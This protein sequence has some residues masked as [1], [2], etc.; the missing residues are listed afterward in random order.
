MAESDPTGELESAI[1]KL[2]EQRRAHEEAIEE[3]DETFARYG[4]RPE[5]VEQP[6]RGKKKAA[7]KKAGARGKKKKKTRA[8]GKKKAATRKK[9]T[10]GKKRSSRRY[11][12]GQSSTDF[13]LSV[14][15]ERGPMT[16][17]ELSAAWKEAGR[18]GEVHQHL[19]RLLRAGRIERNKI[20]GGRTSQYSA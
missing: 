6:R 18:P 9:K 7:G 8:A 17:S 1:Q 11:V 5:E 15:Q 10:G 12:G 20:E 2:L 14:L 13:L 3:I 4:V 16:T 19:A